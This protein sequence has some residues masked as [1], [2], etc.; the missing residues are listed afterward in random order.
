MEIITYFAIEIYNIYDG[1]Y[2]T[3]ETFKDEDKAK[4]YLLANYQSPNAKV[5]KLSLKLIV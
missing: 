5:N 2:Y 4:A 1:E 3:Y